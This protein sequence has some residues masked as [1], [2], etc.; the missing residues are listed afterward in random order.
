[1][2]S[3][4]LRKILEADD[5]GLLDTPERPAAITAD[6]RLVASFLEINAFIAKQGRE[7]DS[8]AK[9]MT[10]RRLA[11]R[12][13]GLRSSPEKAEAL[14]EHDTH[15]LLEDVEPPKTLADILVEDDPL[16]T[17]PV[18]DDL[19]TLRNVPSSH[20]SPE[21]VARQRPCEDFELFEHLFKTCH[22]ELN[23]GQRVMRTLGT[24]RQ[25][26]VGEY[27]V[28][29]G[30]LIYIAEVGEE[31]D[32]SHNRRDARLRVIY[33]NGTESDILRRSLARNVRHD[34]RWVVRPEEA[35]LEAFEQESEDDETTGWIYVLA[36]LS[37]DSQVRDIE[38]LH[39]IGFSTKPVDE[40]I[41]DAKRDPTYFMAPVD[42]VAS[43][44]CLNM[45]VQKFENLLHRLFMRVR[46]STEIVGRDG[47]KYSADEW[48]VVP[49]KVIDEAVQLIINGE[50]VNYIYD[51]AR[52]Q[53]VE[54]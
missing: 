11:S 17:D 1:M 19:L 53:L 40:R 18:A 36:S 5:S 6:D 48:F 31:F 27:F 47:M 35:Q 24:E 29:R 32:V 39:K 12:L 30:Q 21:Y 9:S 16:L 14:K 23:S 34:G 10:E 2:I 4:E 33:E 13:E 44:R 46:L 8:S 38:N 42:V 51:D 41:K 54:R 49:F 15:G 3:D 7:P 52:E 45:N 37:D 50:I 28:L 20:E 22:Q 25:I 43:Y 26:D